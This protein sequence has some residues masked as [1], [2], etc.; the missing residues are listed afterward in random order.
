M[1]L[2][3]KQKNIFI[4]LKSEESLF[5]LVSYFTNTFPNYGFFLFFWDEQKKVFYS[6]ES[7]VKD[8][9]AE[10]FF[11]DVVINLLPKNSRVYI[12]IGQK[13]EKMNLTKWQNSLA[14]NLLFAQ[15]SNIKRLF[16]KFNLKTPTFKNID[17]TITPKELFL[18][19]PQPSRIF[20]KTNDFFSEKISSLEE[21]EKVMSKINIGV[22]NYSIEEYID[23][24]DWYIFIYKKDGQVKTHF[25]TPQKVSSKVVQKTEDKIMNL[26]AQAFKDFGIEKYALF[27]FIVDKSD[28]IYFLN[29]FTELYIF[30]GIHKE[31]MNNIFKKYHFN[32]NDILE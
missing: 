1:V 8:L 27:H 5:D 25:Y 22:D 28:N 29:I 11:A 14:T 17:A 21:L 20:S 24:I 4:L 3:L 15:K 19:F 18:N 12:D 2:E 32:L 30:T 31:I 23:G 16:V 13:M 26:S 7:G 9:F 10:L 6:Q